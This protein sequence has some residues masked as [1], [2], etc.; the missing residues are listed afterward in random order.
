MTSFPSEFAVYVGRARQF[1][2]RDWAVYVAWVGLMLGLVVATGGFLVVGRLAG[3][4]FPP[5]AYWVPAGA[6]I[7]ALA[8]AIDTIGH[9]TVYKPVIQEAEGLVHGVTIFCGIASS[10]ALTAA[11]EHRAAFWIPAAVLTVLSF[12]YSLF[13]EAMHWKRYATGASDRVEMWSHVFIFVGHGIMM[14]AWWYWFATGYAGVAETLEHLP[15]V[16]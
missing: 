2:P 1:S 16:T 9:R 10:V 12:V 5:E 7:F 11:Y 13:D 6:A 3:V 15:R 4:A 14:T 8:I